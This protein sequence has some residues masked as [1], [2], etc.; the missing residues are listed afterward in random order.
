MRDQTPAVECATTRQRR[1]T[2]MKTRGGLATSTEMMSDSH[3]KILGQSGTS[4]TMS[5][6]TCCRSSTGSRW[7]YGSV[8][9]T[10]TG[11]LERENDSR[12]C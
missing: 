11:E 6:K 12:S 1:H 5:K 9:V 2:L 8:G 7:M 4:L 3:E 10:L